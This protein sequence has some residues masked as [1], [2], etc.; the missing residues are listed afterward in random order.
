MPFWNYETSPLSLFL[1]LTRLLQPLSIHSSSSSSSSGFIA[2]ISRFPSLN[3]SVAI[4]NVQER[5]QS[6]HPQGCWLWLEG[7]AHAE[8]RC[9]FWTAMRRQLISKSH[10]CI[11]SELF[12][13]LISCALAFSRTST[14]TP[15]HTWKEWERVACW[16]KPT[17]LALVRK[18]LL[19]SKQH[20]VL[21]NPFDWNLP[22]QH[23]LFG[24]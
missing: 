24:C 1:P 10:T 19:I 16:I 2:R 17:H 12:W 22:L 23:I 14:N 5:Q 20:L 9:L 18:S 11:L 7:L 13:R 15:S 6:E 21:I 8:W 4:P 3:W